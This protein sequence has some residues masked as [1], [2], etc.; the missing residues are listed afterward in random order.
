MRRITLLALRFNRAAK[1]RFALL[2]I[3]AAVGM[4]LFLIVSELSRLSS[5]DLRASIAA[6]AGRTG[7][8]SID[9][10]S[11]FG[12]DPRSLASAVDAAVRPYAAQPVQMLEIIPAV[13]MGCPPD[14]SLGAQPL[15]VPYGPAGTPIDRPSGGMPNVGPTCIGGQEVPASAFRFPSEAERTLWFGASSASSSVG[16]V[17]RGRYER[18]AL[19]T[20][21]AA[22]SYRFIVVTGQEADVSFP[23]FGAVTQA[24]HGAAQRYGAPHV[25]SAVGVTRLDTGQAIRRAAAGVDLVYGI[26][27]W[28]FL[29]LAGLGLLVAETIVVR[30]RMWFFGL[31]RAVGARGRDIAA[32]VV[33]D[34][35]L[36]LV[37]ASVL[38]IV[39]LLVLGPV[40]GSFARD[41]FQVTGVSFLKASVAPRLLLGGLLVLLLAAAYPAAKAVRQDPLDVLEPRVS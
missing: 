23:L 14:T 7:T 16:L 17:P 39:L 19:L 15:I 13:P 20:T 41:A 27:A 37:A 10:G 3:S 1:A 38:T 21:T 32:L 4:A 25:A 11:T 33:V 2:A 6:E 18:L 35:V 5:E 24:L 40:A 26:I 29:V 28:A 36:V 31:S 22:P 34:I 30:D 12:M 8:Y 9:L